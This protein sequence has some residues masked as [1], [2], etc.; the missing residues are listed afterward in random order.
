MI[1]AIYFDG[2]AARL[3][4]VALSIH[5]SHVDVLTPEFTRRFSAETVRVAEPF[6][7]APHVLEF[8]HGARCEI[9]APADKKALL[10]ALAAHRL[11]KQSFVQRWQGRW[12]GALAAMLLMAA[13]LLLAYTSGIP[14]AIDKLAARIPAVMEKD[15]GDEAFVALDSSLLRPSR[16]SPQRQQEAQEVFRR[17]VPPDARQPMQL[18]I[19]DA[20]G[21]AP[22]ALA[23][24]N[25]IVVLSDAMVMQVAGTAPKFTHAAREKLAGVLAH[26]I[27]HVQARHSVRKLVQDS[28]TGAVSWALFGDFSVA[29]AG[30][31]N[32]LLKME[33]SRDMETEADDY[34]M[35]VLHQHGMSPA[36]FAELL[37]SLESEP[38]DRTQE[39]PGWWK[40]A[41]S[42]LSSH[43]NRND[44]VARLRRPQ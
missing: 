22:M 10:A 31:P 13:L 14:W 9:H 16:L 18:I 8:G 30:A 33:Y 2:R 7:G 27:G 25:G 23:L 19:R 6:A 36:G 37:S 35:A 24:P 3:Q 32:L 34:A 26:E 5:E 44:R 40:T 12:Q 41:S 21:M 17:L 11:C 20:P 1:P 4:Q 42:Y 38:Q 15:L 43:P 29:A 39:L 28:L